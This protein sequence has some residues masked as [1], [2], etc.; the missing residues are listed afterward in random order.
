MTYSSREWEIAGVEAA[1]GRSEAQ[2]AAGLRLLRLV[3]RR[4]TASSSPAT[5]ST[6]AVLSGPPPSSA[7]ADRGDPCAAGDERRRRA[8]ES[9]KRALLVSCWATS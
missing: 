7:P 8:E 1:R 4:P 2:C 5:T 9:V 6:A 3:G